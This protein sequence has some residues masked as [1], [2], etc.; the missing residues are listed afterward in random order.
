MPVYWPFP[1]GYPRGQTIPTCCYDG[2]Q[3]KGWFRNLRLTAHYITDH[4]VS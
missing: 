4:C 1:T 2:R 3:F